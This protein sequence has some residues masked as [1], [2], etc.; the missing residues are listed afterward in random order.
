MKDLYCKND[1][2]VAGPDP[3]LRVWLSASLMLE[4]DKPIVA[5]CGF[6]HGISTC[7][8]VAA[9]CRI[10][11]CLGLMMRMTSQ[12]LNS[13]FQAWGKRFH[14]ATW[15]TLFTLFTRKTHSVRKQIPLDTLTVPGYES[16]DYKT[17]VIC[18]PGLLPKVQSAL[19]FVEK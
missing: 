17:L 7:I 15:K 3:T 2:W 11:F 14:Q 12:M 18:G 9:V 10:R 16:S 13:L 1:S 5:D 19:G 4:L 6:G 8:V